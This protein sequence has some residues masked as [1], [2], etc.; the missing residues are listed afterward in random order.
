M[1]LVREPLHEARLENPRRLFVGRGI[2]VLSETSSTNDICHQYSADAS[3]SGL[4]VFAEHQVAGRG[5]QG[6]VWVA[7]PRAG[8]LFS[9]LLFPESVLASAPFLTAWAALGVAECLHHHYHLHPRVKW[10]NDVLLGG[11]KVCGVLVERRQA[12]VVGFGLNVSHQPAEFPP[13]T[14]MPPTSLL[15]ATGQEIDRTTL[16]RQL[17]D[18]LE[19]CFASA[20]ANGPGPL[21]DRW[22]SWSY[23]SPGDQVRAVTHRQ[24][25]VG[26]L[27]E[28]RPDRGACVR[29]AGDSISWITAAEL[30]RVEPCATEST[31]IT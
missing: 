14:R 26:E 3:M 23:P 12:T 10:P 27:L 6:R 2:R 1:T 7:P 17:L 19:D 15:L 25:Y 4:A 18:H 30:L 11:K 13:E 28:I 31:I 29:C 16:A 5:Q 9:V 8:L 22:Q 21:W 20:V 24:E